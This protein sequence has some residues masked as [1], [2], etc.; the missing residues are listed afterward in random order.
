MKIGTLKEIKT[1]EYRVGLT[2][3]CVKAYVARG[4]EV[5]VEAG[6]GANTG[7]LDSEYVSA[8][9]TIEDSRQKICDDCE[10]IIKV[11]EPQ[12]NECNSIS[13]LVRLGV[14]RIS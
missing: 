5:F 3:A 14:A 11:K 7:Y 8:G 6:A 4:H 12:P 13:V 10:M 1:H 2:P 9:A